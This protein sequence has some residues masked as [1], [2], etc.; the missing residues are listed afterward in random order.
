MKS[1]L[2]FCMVGCLILSASTNAQ[3]PVEKMQSFYH[4]TQINMEAKRLLKKDRDLKDT[5]IDVTV[6]HGNIL[7]AGQT[8]DPSQKQH[9]EELMQDIPNINRVHNQI[10]I[11]G[12]A[13]ALT[14]SSDS[15]ITT[16]VKSEMI[17][18]KNLGARH[19]KVLTENGVVYI[20]G[21]TTRDEADIATEIARR[22]GGVQKVVRLFE[23]ID[24]D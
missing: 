5:H 15:W 21:R 6:N 22:V 14:R 13:S 20:M 2:L 16:K 1:T 11:S 9:A 8:P 17:L 3:S 18:E 23:Y 4:D 7:L 12:P 24:D 19:I 10:T